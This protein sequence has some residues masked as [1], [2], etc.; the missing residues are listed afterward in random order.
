MTC[1]KAVKLKTHVMLFSPSHTYTHRQTQSSRDTW[2][3]TEKQTLR[4]S[5][6]CFSLLSFPVIFMNEWMRHLFQNVFTKRYDQRLHWQA[7]GHIH[8][9][10]RVLWNVTGGTEQIIKE[11]TKRSESRC[12]KLHR[13]TLHMKYSHEIWDLKGKGSAKNYSE[14]ML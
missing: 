6:D 3:D 12:W 1:H 4:V 10:A 7:Q 11:T 8:V 2:P 13:V 14:F 9:K 5:W